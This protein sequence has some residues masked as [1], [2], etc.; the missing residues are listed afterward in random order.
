MVGR[1]DIE[2]WEGVI[3]LSSSTK[4]TIGGKQKETTFVRDASW[5]DRGRK[6]KLVRLD[7]R[8]IPD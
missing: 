3:F 4:K 8:K 5:Y 7:P 1:N 6:I 2:G